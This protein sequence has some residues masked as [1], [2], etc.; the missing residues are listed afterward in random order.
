MQMKPFTSENAFLIFLTYR[1]HAL[2][3]EVAT[4]YLSHFRGAFGKIFFFLNL[5]SAFST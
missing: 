5:I 4:I 1:K 3:L 2:I